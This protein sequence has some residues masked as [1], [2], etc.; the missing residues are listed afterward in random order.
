MKNL[1]YFPEFLEWDDITF[2]SQ[3][4]EIGQEHENPNIRDLASMIIPNMTS[5]LN[6]IYYHLDIKNSSSYS[7]NDI[8]FLKKIKTIIKSSGQFSKN[9]KNSN[10]VEQNTFIGSEKIPLSSYLDDKLISNFSYNIRAYKKKKPIYVK[11]KSGEI[12]E[13]SEHPDRRYDWNERQIPLQYEYCYIPFLRFNGFSETE[14]NELRSIFSP[15]NPES[16]HS[17]ILEKKTI[18]MHEYYTKN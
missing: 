3:I 2:Y 6:M 15:T 17:N 7:A 4:I 14:I 9:L 5:F 1:F 16:H 8:A 18:N 11:D 10:F 13:L 12:Y